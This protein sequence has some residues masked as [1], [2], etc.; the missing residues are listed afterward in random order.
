MDD[1]MAKPSGGAKSEVAPGR[2]R[3][4]TNTIILSAVVRT[5]GRA[6]PYRSRANREAPKRDDQRGEKD[7]GLERPDPLH[8]RG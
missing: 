6:Q 3:A 4:T 7:I 1:H 2:S 5:W 8:Q